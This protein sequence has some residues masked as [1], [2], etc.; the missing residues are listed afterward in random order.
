MRPQ[1]PPRWAPISWRSSGWTPLA[2]F[3]TGKTCG[4]GRGPKSGLRATGQP[5][6]RQEPGLEARGA[7]GKAAL[8]DTL[9]FGPAPGILRAG[10]NLAKRELFQQISLATGAGHRDS[11]ACRRLLGTC[12][13]STSGAGA[14]EGGGDTG[15]PCPVP[16]GAQREREGSVWDEAER[17]LVW[18]QSNSGPGTIKRDLFLG[19]GLSLLWGTEWKMYI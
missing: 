5:G 16:L 12:C 9:G 4:S 19:S 11:S 8:G 17:G 7:A 1:S 6:L 10:E 3:G 18:R 15:P 2:C 14:G 13:C